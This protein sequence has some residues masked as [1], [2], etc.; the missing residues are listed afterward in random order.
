VISLLFVLMVVMLVVKFW[1]FV[2]AALVLYG[3]WRFGIEPYRE[4][5]AR[6]AR[7]RLRH[8]RTRQEI[9][10]IAFVTARAMYEAAATAPGEVIEGTA[11]EVER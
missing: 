9:D 1:H 4:A 3:V 2:A 7:E 6:Q 8:A 10:D 5:Q 11:I